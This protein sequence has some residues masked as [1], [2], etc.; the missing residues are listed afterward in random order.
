MP[1]EAMRQ[2]LDEAAP[3]DDRVHAFKFNLRA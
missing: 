1:P 2:L 3:G